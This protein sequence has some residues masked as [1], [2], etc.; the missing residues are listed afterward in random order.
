M[1]SLILIVF[2]ESLESQRGHAALKKEWLISGGSWLKH[3]KE[4]DAIGSGIFVQMEA[5][6]CK[7]GLAAYFLGE[8]S[9]QP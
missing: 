4:V 1:T 2:L 3:F 8:P 9:S 6:A 5:F 7:T